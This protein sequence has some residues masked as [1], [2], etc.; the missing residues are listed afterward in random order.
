LSDEETVVFNLEVQVSEMS[1]G[2]LR[3]LELIAYRSIALLRRMGLPEQIDQGI[4]KLQ[5]FIMIIRLAH[6]ALVAFNAASLTNPL[7][8]A[9]FALSVGTLAFATTDFIMSTGG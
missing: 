6:T 4:A 5:N 1:M 2:N 3:K 7:G 9:M 8:L